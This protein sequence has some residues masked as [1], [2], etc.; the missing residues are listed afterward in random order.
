MATATD[1]TRSDA[2]QRLLI[3][4]GTG[5]VGSRLAAEARTRGH[6]VTI[7]S[8]RAQ[9]DQEGMVKVDASS[10]TDLEGVLGSSAG[11]NAVLV[12][13]GPSRTN[14][15]AAP[16]ID[17]YK[18][19]ISAC[20][21]TGTR[22]FFVGGAGS[23][24]TQDGGLQMNAPGFPDFVKPEAQAHADALDWLRTVDDVDWTSLAPPPM[25]QPGTRTG[26]YKLGQDTII[27]FTI[28]AEDYAV[29]ALDEIDAKKHIKARFAVA[30]EE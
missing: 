8:R 20:R 26:K 3:L 28:S 1:D 2:C 16:L 17:V 5:M 21:T 19:I 23:L 30:A 12:A 9:E 4:G 10:S 24:Q 22:V 29:A 7:G 27:G 11:Y 14:P 13:L 6:N 18:S 25:I 15:D